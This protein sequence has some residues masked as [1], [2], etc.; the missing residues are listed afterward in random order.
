MD[1]PFIDQKSPIRFPSFIDTKLLNKWTKVMLPELAG[2][3][4]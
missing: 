1:Q 3:F 2:H 4:K